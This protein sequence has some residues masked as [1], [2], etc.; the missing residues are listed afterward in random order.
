[1]A[2]DQKSALTMGLWNN[3]GTQIQKRVVSFGY[4]FSGEAEPPSSVSR[5]KMGCLNIA[6]ESFNKT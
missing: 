2:V 6:L 4:W 1:M 3:D 5:R